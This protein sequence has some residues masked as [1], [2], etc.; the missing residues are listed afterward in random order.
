[1][2]VQRR[3]RI[4]R[5]AHSR[6]SAAG[7]RPEH[8]IPAATSRSGPRTSPPHCD[9]NWINRDRGSGDEA[10]ETVAERVLLQSDDDGYYGHGIHGKTR[11]EPT[12]IRI[13]SV[14][15]RGFR[16]YKFK[17]AG[18]QL[19]LS[20]SVIISTSGT[21]PN[22][23]KPPAIGRDCPPRLRTVWE[24]VGLTLILLR[25]WESGPTPPACLVT[26]P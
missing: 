5:G 25:R 11:K 2:R 13:V 18:T 16:G 7:L 10:Q 3:R 4:V 8:P 20:A 17:N 12:P 15:F 19:N 24:A 6:I 22:I 26:N 23:A 1:M 14:F 21:R 9:R